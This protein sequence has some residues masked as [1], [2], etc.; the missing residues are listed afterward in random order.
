MGWDQY[1]QGIRRIGGDPSALP[2]TSKEAA[3]SVAAFVE[4]HIEQGPVLEIE[5]LPIGVVTN[6]VG[7][8][9]YRVVLKGQ[10]DHAGTTPMTVRSDAFVAAARIIDA[11]SSKALAMQVGPHYVVATIGHLV[12]T[13]N[14]SN[15]VPGRVEMMLEVRSD[16]GDVLQTFCEPWLETFRPQVDAL[17]VHLSWTEISRS[18]PT[19]CSASVMVQIEE[20]SRML[21]HQY[22]RMPSGA[23][24]DAAYLA[25]AGPAGMIF[26]PCLKGRSHC[27]EE[28]VTADQLQVGCQVLY[29]TILKLDQAIARP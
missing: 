3:D 16:S 11:V 8:R 28:W 15:A 6:I 2:T 9:R 24:H 19:D 29:Q 21:G 1:R 17:R 12:L 25:K 20:A 13:P 27:P 26:I 22:K 23:G 7:I 10:P 5:Q 4:L 14:A 18:D